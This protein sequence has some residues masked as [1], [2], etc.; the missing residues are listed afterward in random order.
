MPLVGTINLCLE[1][2]NS[3]EKVWAQ[4]DHP[5]WKKRP[6]CAKILEIVKTANFL[7]FFFF[8]LS[9]WSNWAQNFFYWIRNLETQVYSTNKGHFGALKNVNIFDFDPRWGDLRKNI[10]TWKLYFWCSIV[11][12]HQ[13]KHL[14]KLFSTKRGEW[15]TLVDELTTHLPTH[16]QH[17]SLKPCG[18][19]NIWEFITI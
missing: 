1:M 14:A 19:K 11:I 15:H 17:R 3:I 2:P 18:L 10:L 7:C 8:F 12:E 13:I 4:S 6:K 9:H 5:V 16:P